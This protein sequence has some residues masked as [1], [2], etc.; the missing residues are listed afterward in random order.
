[1]RTATKLTI[2][3]VA[4]MGLSFTAIGAIV[5]NEAQ[6]TASIRV[7][8][9]NPA[10]TIDPQPSRNPHYTYEPAELNA[11]VGQ[12]ITIT[13]NDSRGVHSVTADD[14]SFNVDVPPNSSVTLTIEQAGSFPYDCT[15]HPGEHN[16]ASINVS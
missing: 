15:Y 12:P 6:A 2:A 1:M 9:P 4:V 3:L 13:N 16:P 7:Q 11:T 5:E 8:E 10:I 14:R